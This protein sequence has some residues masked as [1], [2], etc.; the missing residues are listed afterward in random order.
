MN[1]MTIPSHTDEQ[2]N[3]PSFIRAEDFCE[4]RFIF[5]MSTKSLTAY[6]QDHAAGAAGA[7]DLVRHLISI[8]AGSPDAK[9]FENLRTQIEED[10]ATLDELLSRLRASESKIFNAMSR[11]GEKVARVKLLLAGSSNEDLGRLEALDALSLGIEGKRALWLALATAA[12]PKLQTVDF[13]V[14]AR[15]AV[16]QRK[17][18]ERRRLAVAT[19][20][21]AAGV[22]RQKLS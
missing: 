10:R 19:R 8:Y 11:A 17:G 4:W 7:L 12:V 2:P 18:V 20:V 22:A 14:L 3:L 6:L 21:L 16:A 5:Q 15:R 1:K 9:F 13:A